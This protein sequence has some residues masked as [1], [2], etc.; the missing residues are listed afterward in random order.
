M[1]M[2]G[3]KVT[4]ADVK[5]IKLLLVQGVPRKSI[6]QA[7]EFSPATIDRVQNGMYDDNGERTDLAK[8]GAKPRDEA[9][10]NLLVKILYE[11]CRTNDLL[12]QLVEKWQ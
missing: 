4:A 5:K 1:E 3:Q 2:K 12:K 6:A 8:Y 11:S 10:N 7:L 9:D